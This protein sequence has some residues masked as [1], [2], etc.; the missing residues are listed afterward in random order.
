MK[1]WCNYYRL[2]KKF[3]KHIVGNVIKNRFKYF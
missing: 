2:N 1:K 3:E